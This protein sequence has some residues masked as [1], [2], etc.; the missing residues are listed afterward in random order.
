[1]ASR[2][3]ELVGLGG[4]IKCVFGAT[5]APSAS[6]DETRGFSVGSMWKAV[7]GALY[8][9]DDPSEGAA[10][11]TGAPDD[12]SPSDFGTL[13][14]DFDPANAVL[15]SG[16]VASVTAGLGAYASAAAF[17]APARPTLIAEDPDFNGMPSFLFDEATPMLTTGP[18]AVDGPIITTVAV[19]RLGASTSARVIVETSPTD[20]SNPLSF[21]MYHDNTTMIT[22]RSGAN[23][24]VC[25]R[26]RTIADYDALL[27]YGMTVDFSVA[28]TG[29]VAHYQDGVLQSTTEDFDGGATAGS[30]A[31]S[32]VWYFGARSDGAPF[33]SGR[34]ARVL[35]FLGEVDHAGLYEYLANIYGA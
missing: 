13:V 17:A 20:N 8:V 27:Y 5:D 25:A 22:H 18:V 1:V 28:G 34:I 21:V 31:G 6:D 29:G 32:Y 24:A 12:P 15:D 16:Y 14:V 4:S 11:W 30:P 2:T 10:S 23:G 26:D 35:G 7:G 33:V 3:I 9:C 19:C